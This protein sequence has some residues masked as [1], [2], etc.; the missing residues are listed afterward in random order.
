MKK[1]FSLAGAAFT[2]FSIATVMALI[3]AAVALWF[4][5][6]LDEGR[7]YRVLAAL[8]GIDMVAMQQQL[9][10]EENEIDDEMPSYATRRK[11]LTLK[12]LDQELRKSAIDNAWAD[13][14]EMRTQLEMKSKQ[15][16]EIKENYAEKLQRTSDE[17]QAVALKEVR[18]T[19]EAIKSEQAK[20]QI[21]KMLEDDAMDDVVTIMKNMPIDKRKRIIGEFEQGPDVEALYK[22]LSNIREGEPLASEIK[23]TQ[24]KLKDF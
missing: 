13:M 24:D 4:K 23:E 10:T 21:L 19:L 9:L 3:T 18:R 15:F 7:L 11:L 22:I 12:S 8:H 16:E 5:G 2:Y 20:E 6:A 17:E 14:N 1:I